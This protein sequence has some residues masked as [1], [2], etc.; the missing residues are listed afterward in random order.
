[1]PPLGVRNGSLRTEVASGL[2]TLWGVA[3]ACLPCFPS[4]LNV[5][6]PPA[7]LKLS[8]MLESPEEFGNLA[9]RTRSPKSLT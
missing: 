9:A 6:L 4:L 3:L 7:F 5:T 1:M 8:S 2:E